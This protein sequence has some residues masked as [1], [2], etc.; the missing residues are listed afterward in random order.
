MSKRVLTI[1]FSFHLT[2]AFVFIVLL[3]FI[4][5]QQNGYECKSFGEAFRSGSSSSGQK[6][7]RRR[8]I[9]KS[10]PLENVLN[11]FLLILIN[12]LMKKIFFLIE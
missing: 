2:V 9:L 12:L 3:S 4:V 8:M 6:E 11:L 1:L 10:T 5:L 7:I